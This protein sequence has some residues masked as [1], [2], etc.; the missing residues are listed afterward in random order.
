MLLL[1]VLL[2]FRLGVCHLA[3]DFRCVSR[4]LSDRC[5]QV[6]V[7]CRVVVGAAGL[8]SDCRWGSWGDARAG[9][10]PVPVFDVYGCD[11]IGGGDKVVRD[12]LVT[13]VAYMI[14]VVIMTLSA[15]SE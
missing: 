14:V 4:C 9:A 10:H 3:D 1:L 5:G 8:M 15:S 13:C 11:G 6:G 7:G 2:G 12:F